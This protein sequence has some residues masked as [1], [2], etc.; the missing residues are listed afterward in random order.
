M[1][2][3]P[4]T[5]IGNILSFL[6]TKCYKEECHFVNDKINYILPN[7]SGKAWC[8]RHSF[9]IKRPKDT[10][11]CGGLEQT[12][13]EW[14]LR[15]MFELVSYDEW[16]DTFKLG[17]LYGP[18]IKTSYR[19]PINVAGYRDQPLE[20]LQ[21]TLLFF[22]QHPTGSTYFLSTLDP[23]VSTVY[24]ELELETFLEPY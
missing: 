2:E 20:Q 1:E 9:R 22:Y 12:R 6:Y 8:D 14:A 23:V 15:N 7:D 17:R 10:P 11:F 5:V 13:I 16:T 18:R 19:H 3:L 24:R 21:R 4:Y